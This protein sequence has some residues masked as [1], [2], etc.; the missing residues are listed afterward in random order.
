MGGN[1][2]PTKR[3]QENR[4]MLDN[5]GCNPILA[6][7]IIGMD[8]SNPIEVR[9]NALKEVA[10]YHSPQLKSIETQVETGPQKIEIRWA[11][12]QKIEPKQDD[13]EAPE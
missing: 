8:T 2:G 7:A 4:E 9:V 10:K 6:L 1:R 13:E 5:L 3:S 12:D 11:N